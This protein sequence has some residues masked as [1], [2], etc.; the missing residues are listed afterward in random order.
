MPGLALSGW[1]DRA[2]DR[3]GWS[4]WHSRLLGRLI[5]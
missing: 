4:T 3:A 2:E 1:A 5:G